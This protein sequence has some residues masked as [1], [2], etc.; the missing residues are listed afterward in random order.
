MVAFAS[1]ADIA[2]QTARIVEFAEGVYGYVSQHDPNCGFVVGDEYVLVIDTRATPA[3]ARAWI[4]DIRTVTD[5][6]IR[7]AFLTHYHA[8]RAMG[9][10]AFGDA[11]IVASKAT[12]ALLTERGQGDFE[13]EMQRMPRLFEGFEEIPGLTEPHILFDEEVTIKV[14]RRS[15]HLMHIG[16]GHTA[17]DS[18]C[19]IPDCGVL[20]GGDLIENRTGI[21]CGDAYIRDWL[22][23]LERLRAFAPKVL[24]PGRGAPLTTLQAVSDAVDSHKNF[25][26][27]LLRTVQLGLDKGADL[28]G[29]Y[30]L[31]REKITPLYGDWPVYDHI[32]P[33]G[34]ARAY[35]ELR[36]LQHPQ[37]WTPE[38]DQALWK[39]VHPG[40]KSS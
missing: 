27:T 36:G 24:V 23:T 16:R 4:A 40:G 3:A 26:V 34:V 25:L 30:R 15:I 9:A 35:D 32:L 18:I 39:A 6:P 17:G 5:K 2:N 31:A 11:A 8:V 19:W 12:G 13:A 33:F 38:R 1:T 22:Q 28:P 7:Y 37:I 10:S 29:C 21:Y 14:G 20:F